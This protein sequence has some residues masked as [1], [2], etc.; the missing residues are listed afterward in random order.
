MK[1]F[2]Y[3]LAVLPLLLTSCHKEEK[4]NNFAGTWYSDY[5]Y[6][7][8]DETGFVSFVLR[9]EDVADYTKG[10]VVLTFNYEDFDGVLDFYGDYFHEEYNSVGCSVEFD[11][12]GVRYEWPVSVSGKRLT[13]YAPELVDGKETIT[14]TKK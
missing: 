1:R 11:V 5:R 2:I 13:L 10:E 4:V 14:F 3:L 7:S 12:D 6:K 8:S 9:F